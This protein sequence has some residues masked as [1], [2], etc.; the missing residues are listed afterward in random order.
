[1]SPSYLDLK[2]FEFV[3]HIKEDG[4]KRL[5]EKFAQYLAGREPASAHLRKE[6]HMFLHTGWERFARAHNLEAG[7]LVNFKWEV[8]DELRVKVFN[9]TSCYRHYHSDNNDE[10]SDDEQ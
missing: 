2:F 1:M 10:G 8:D 9:D 6:G 3:V 7:C 5:L 4:S